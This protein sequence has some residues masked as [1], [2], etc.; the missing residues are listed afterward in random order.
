WLLCSLRPLPLSFF[1]FN[2]TATTEIYTLSLH[3]ALPISVELR[4]SKICR[5]LAQNLIGL[6]QL[7]D[8]AFQR[9]ELVGDLGR[10]TGTLAAVDL[11]LLHPLKQ[12]LRH[13]ADLLRNRNHRRPARGV[14]PLVI[15]NHPYRAFADFRRELVRCLAHTG[16]TFSGVGAS[17]KP[18]AVHFGQIG[19]VLA[20]AGEAHSVQAAAGRTGLRL[21]RNCPTSCAPSSRDGRHA[22][23][24]PSWLQIGRAHV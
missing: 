18:G 1:S 21:E 19:A 20:A 3:D 22:G 9:L 7:A 14:I 6:T 2:H 11:R 5:R 15:E 12:R 8:L 13:A 24:S 16:S 23:R 10:N 4:L 17:G